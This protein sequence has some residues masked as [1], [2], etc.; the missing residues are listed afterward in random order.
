MNQDNEP[1]R[2][3]EE[4]KEGVRI[5][6]VLTPEPELPPAEKSSEKKRASTNEA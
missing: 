6:G 3:V 1:W 2:N 5:Y 4:T